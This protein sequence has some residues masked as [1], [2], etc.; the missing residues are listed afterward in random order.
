M[1]NQTSET[2]RLVQAKISR[3]QRVKGV[4]GMAILA[5]CPICHRKQATKNKV[6]SCGEDLVRAKRS[7]RVRYW[8]NYRLPGGRQRREAVGYSIEEA[9]DADGKRRGQKRENRIFD[10]KPEA[11]MTFEQLTEWYLGLGR[12]KA[13]A[14]YWRIKISLDNFNSEL[15]SIL[16]R[17]IR[18]SQ[19]ENYQQKRLNQGKAPATVDRE[20]GEVKTMIYKA[21]NDGMVDDRIAMAFK[22]VKKVLK[23]NA[24]AR[25]TILPLD[26][27]QR[28]LSESPPHL[29]GILATGFYTGMRKGEIL[30]LTWDKVD[31]EN[32]FVRLEATDTKDNEPRL[33]PICD[34]LYEI[35]KRQPVAL[36]HGHVFTYKGNPIKT[37]FRRSL[38]KACERAEIPHGRKVKGGFTFHDLRHTF[39]TFMR[40][41][42]VAESV[43]MQITGHSTR[44]MFDR[45]NTIDADDAR[46]A[47]QRFKR[48]LGGNVLQSV[49]QNVD[50]EAKKG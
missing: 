31:L 21:H 25:N 46:D 41:A 2:S 48:F 6:C 23:R 24:N 27:F 47:I 7:K 5:E 13:L 35:L 18:L 40:K 45:Y 4:T 10:I 42:G 22:K 32:R 49:D 15:G 38:A 16:V 34:E 14:S 17:N 43:I 9:R 29:F 44:E 20:V 36:H 26:K 19:I 28:L 50:Q 33:V 1:F 3:R 11:K 39:N 30:G 12:V 8:I 37:N